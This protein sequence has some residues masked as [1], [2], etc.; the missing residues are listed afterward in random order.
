MRYL[1]VILLAL[2]MSANATLLPKQIRGISEWKET[3]STVVFGYKRIYYISPTGQKGC[4]ILQYVP[5][6]ADHVVAVFYVY[7]KGEWVKVYDMS[8]ESNELP[9][10]QGVDI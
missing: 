6:I 9:Q 7:I 2:S 5:S 10:V 4:A 1:L 8:E 3:S